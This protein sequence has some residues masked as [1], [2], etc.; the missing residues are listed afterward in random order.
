PCS[1]LHHTGY[2]GSCQIRCQRPAV[3]H[4][5]PSCS[6]IFD[7]PCVLAPWGYLPLI[8]LFRQHFL[9]SIDILRKERYICGMERFPHKICMENGKEN[10]SYVN[11][12][13]PQLLFQPVRR[14]RHHPVFLRSASYHHFQSKSK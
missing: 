9:F 6:R 5:E 3:P 7:L 10:P 14:K 13:A 1:F 2:S 12:K 11:G 8:C 4:T